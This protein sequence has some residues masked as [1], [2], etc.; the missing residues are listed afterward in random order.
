MRGEVFAQDRSL[1][2]RGSPHSIGT[3]GLH[4]ERMVKTVVAYGGWSRDESFEAEGSVQGN[5]SVQEV[6]CVRVEA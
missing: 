6:L 4:V 1:R 5:A 2:R 3:G